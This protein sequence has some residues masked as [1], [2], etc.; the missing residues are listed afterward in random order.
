MYKNIKIL[1]LHEEAGKFCYTTALES[2]FNSS[3][4]ASDVVQYQY[5]PPI[6]STVYTFEIKS[7]VHLDI[8]EY[9]Y[10]FL[11]LDYIAFT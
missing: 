1:T 2:I 9:K 7:S 11:H 8:F 4:C 3:F 10:N 5:T 6:Y